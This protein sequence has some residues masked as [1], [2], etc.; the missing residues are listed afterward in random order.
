MNDY[1]GFQL[2]NTASLSE[3]VRQ[4]IEMYQRKHGQ[5]PTILEHGGRESAPLPEGLTM[6]VEII[7]IPKNILLIG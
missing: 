6:V 3:N 2:D 5:P 7:R 1:E 4:A